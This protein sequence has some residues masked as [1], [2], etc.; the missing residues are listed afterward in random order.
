MVCLLV[1]ITKFVEPANEILN[2]G[3][4]L[5]CMYAIHFC[6]A[7]FT[8][9]SLVSLEMCVA[10]VSIYHKCSFGQ[11]NILSLTYCI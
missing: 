9:C 6:L 8:V 5:K 1:C 3:K 11:V 10:G 7:W 4:D 2:E